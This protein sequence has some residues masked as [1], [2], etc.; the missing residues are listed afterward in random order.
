MEIALKMPV[1]AALL[2]GTLIVIQ[3]VLMLN[4]GLYRTNQKKGVGIDGDVTLE[5]RVRRHGNLAENAAIFII[6]LT[7]YE[8]LLGQTAMALL[9]AIV[10]AAARL[11][12]IA[13]FANEAGSHL[14][15]VQGRKK[16]FVLMRAVGAGLSALASLMIGVAL[17]YAVVT[18]SM[19]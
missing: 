1:Y 11:S 7:L 13:G 4:V 6:V 12:H 17:V 8:L 3:N 15:G 19:S 18:G 9:S 14:I 5:R 16:I 2:G 10:F